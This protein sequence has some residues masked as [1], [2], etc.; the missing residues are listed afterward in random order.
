MT[1]PTPP[2]DVDLRMRVRAQAT[3][4][5]PQLLD[6]Y[7][8]RSQ[9]ASSTRADC[10]KVLRG[11]SPHLVSG[12]LPL[13]SGGGASS[14]SSSCSEEAGHIVAALEELARGVV[15]MADGPLEVSESCIFSFFP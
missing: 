15:S 2:Q 13:G 4:P 6:Q 14:S 1:Y 7:D 9:G 3:T 5:P 11:V 8:Q 10:L 12:G